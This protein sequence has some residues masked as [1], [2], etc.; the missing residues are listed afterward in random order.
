MPNTVGQ[1]REHLVRDID[2]LIEQ[3]Q[4]EARK[5]GYDEG[6]ADG[7]QRGYDDGINEATTTERLGDNP[8]P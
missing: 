1:L 4:D 5:E 8:N 6:D 2:D 7:Y 3:A